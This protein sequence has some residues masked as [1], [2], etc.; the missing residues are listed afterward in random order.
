MHADSTLKCDCGTSKKS[1][2]LPTSSSA[3][4]VIAGLTGGTFGSVWGVDFPAY[5]WDLA[6]ESP[7]G[8]EGSAPTYKGS[9]N[10]SA[11]CSSGSITGL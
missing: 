7:R 4:C 5:E 6:A 8:I 2:H 11:I 1:N 10:N 9:K 3:G